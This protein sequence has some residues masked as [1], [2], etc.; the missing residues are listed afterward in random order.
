MQSIRHPNLLTFYGAGVNSKHQ[1]YLVTEYMEG[2]SLRLL[3]LNFDRVITWT[4]RLSF[5]KDIARGMKYLHD[6]GTIHR[7]L[8][9][10]N[11]FVDA[12]MRV[13]VADFGTGKIQSRIKKSKEDDDEREGYNLIR[14]TTISTTQEQALRNR[15]LTKGIGTLFW[16]A[17]EVLSGKKILDQNGA[18][19]D[20][21]SFGVV[22]WE[23]WTRG[24]PWDEVRGEGVAFFTKFQ[25]LVLQG[26]R[27]QLPGGCEEAPSGYAELMRLCWAHIA[28]DRPSFAYTLDQLQAI[29]DIVPK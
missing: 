13:K 8:K 4:E 11:C 3:L 27:P 9:A 22:M 10:D 12:R 1:A 5:T 25:Q 19:L 16:M 23:I 26:Q 18:A 24:R 14:T 17:P 15:T 29:S 28:S 6:K 7:D 20:V 21:Y 2:G